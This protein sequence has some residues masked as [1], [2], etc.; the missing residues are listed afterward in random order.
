MNYTSLADKI[1]L[2]G[3]SREISPRGM[4]TM[5]VGGCQETEFDHDAQAQHLLPGAEMWRKCAGS[6]RIL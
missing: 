6:V 3:S 1:Y 4:K 5:K 2:Y